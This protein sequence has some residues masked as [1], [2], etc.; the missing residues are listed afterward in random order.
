VTND[1]AVGLRININEA[2]KLKRSYGAAFEGMG[3]DRDEVQ[4]NQAGGNTKILPAK[5]IS[6]IIQPRCEEMLGMVRKEIQSCCGYELATCGVVMTG[7]ASLLNGFD[8]MAESLLGL[9]VRLGQPVNVKG[10]MAAVRNPAYSTG[11]GLV[12]YGCE[13]SA[14]VGLNTGFLGDAVAGVK[15]WMKGIFNSKGLMQINN[16]KEGGMLCLKSKK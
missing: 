16:K 12:A 2:E 1:I 14:E 15:G 8:K 11:V 9:P 6:E 3:N 7:G 5:Y 4:I 13:Y 10:R